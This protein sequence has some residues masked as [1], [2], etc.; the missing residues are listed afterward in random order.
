M[1]SAA[2]RRTGQQVGHPR[3]EPPRFR[4]R[5][6]LDR[7]AQIL[8]FD[9]GIVDV[10]RNEGQLVRKLLPA[11]IALRAIL[12]AGC[13]GARAMDRSRVHRSGVHIGSR[14]ALPHELHRGRTGIH[15]CRIPTSS[16]IGDPAAARLAGSR[17]APAAGSEQVRR[18]V[19]GCRVRGAIRDYARERDAEMGAA[20]ALANVKCWKTRN[21]ECSKRPRT[22]RLDTGSYEDSINGSHRHARRSTFSGPCRVGRI[23]RSLPGGEADHQDD[24][25]P[26]RI[27]RA[28][29]HPGRNG[30]IIPRE[31]GQSLRPTVFFPRSGPKSMCPTC[32]REQ[33]SGL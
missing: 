20:R 24:I 25:R 18:S 7:S 3:E 10:A 11:R 27:R 16:S 30:G 23:R 6:A 5:W 15:P 4:P 28:S 17:P 29:P 14:R 8:Q 22:S 33:R 32:P 26:H 19:S 9:D 1:P 12:L 31:L 2:Q 21:N 13:V